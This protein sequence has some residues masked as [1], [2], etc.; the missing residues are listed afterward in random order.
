MQKFT[1]QIWHLKKGFY[2]NFHLTFYGNKAVPFLPKF[3]FLQDNILRFYKFFKRHWA[4]WTSSKMKTHKI[5]IPWESWSLLSSSS[6][7]QVIHLTPKMSDF[8]IF[9]LLM[10]KF[11]STASMFVKNFHRHFVRAR[12]FIIFYE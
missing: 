9:S 7:F 5:V 3:K 11:Y 6:S 8:E 4:S 10:W 12:I 1:F 2:A